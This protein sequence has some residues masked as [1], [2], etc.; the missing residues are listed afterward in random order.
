MKSGIGSELKKFLNAFIAVGG[1]YGTYL[2]IKNEHQS[3]GALKELKKE[4]E[5]S[6][7]EFKEITDRRIADNI[8]NRLHFDKISRSFKDLDTVKNEKSELMK[9]IDENKANMTESNKIEIQD[10]LRNQES[11]MD[12][13]QLEEKRINDEIRKSIDNGVK[14]SKEVTN[15]K[16]ESKILEMIN[17]KNKSIFDLDSL[18]SSFE[19]LNGISK[20]AFTM[21]FSSSIIL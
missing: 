7:L 6:K 21:I 16:D 19:S 9:K 18:L 14:F 2:T 5:K 3:I 11:R 1:A 10:K 12:L 15:E 13:L 17:E 4:V 8:S 20:L